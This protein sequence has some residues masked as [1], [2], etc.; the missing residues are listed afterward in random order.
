MRNPA[1]MTNPNP[2]LWF[3]AAADSF[4]IEYAATF[5]SVSCL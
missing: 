1:R 5:Y 3:P 2:L 4:P